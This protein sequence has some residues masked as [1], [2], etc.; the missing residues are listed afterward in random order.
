M[1][2]SNLLLSTLALGACGSSPIVA[3]DAGDSYVCAL[4][5]RG[6]IRCDDIDLSGRDEIIDD[7]PDRGKWTELVVGARHACAL[8]A[9]GYPTCWGL[10]GNEPIADRTPRE[11]LFSIGGNSNTACGLK[12]S[13]GSILCWGYIGQYYADE[14][15]QGSFQWLET[16]EA[17]VCYQRTSGEIG[18]TAVSDYTF[19]NPPVGLYNPVE[20]DARGTNLC[21]TDKDGRITCW[22]RDTYDVHLPPEGTGYHG[23]ALGQKHG[24]A[25]NADN[26]AVCWG[27]D[28]RYGTTKPPSGRFTSIVSGGFYSCGLRENG[29]VECWGCGDDDRFPPD[30]PKML[31]DDE[32]CVWD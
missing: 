25:L 17:K 31:R 7:V 10:I 4:D 15:P 8:D 6:R 29:K 11:K 13:D 16:L 27:N 19:P 30:H 5:K 14:L 26:E 9:E 20:V 3:W 32:F 2:P 21:A 12:Q 1:L 24:C 22:G 28:T 18:C 23:L